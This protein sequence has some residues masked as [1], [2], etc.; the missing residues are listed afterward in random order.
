[1]KSLAEIVKWTLPEYRERHV[2]LVRLRLAI[3]LGFWAI[4]LSF[5]WD[6]LEQVWPTT[7]TVL[8][9]FF[10]TGLSYY[11]VMRDRWLVGSFIIE[12][13]SDLA[14][15]TVVLYLTGGPHS[16]YYTMYVFYVL[17]VGVFYSYSL[18]AIC[19]VVVA[20]CYALF[21]LLCLSG[22]IPPLILDYGDNAPLPGY[23][24]L[25]NYIFTAAFL[26]F[27]IYAVKIASYFSQRREK[28]LELR[29]KEFE[30]LYRMSSTIRSTL[31]LADVRDRVLASVQHGLG[32][33]HVSMLT[34]EEKN[35]TPQ[36]CLVMRR[37]DPL[38]LQL[39]E[40]F[41]VTEPHAS[42][43]RDNSK[44]LLKSLLQGKIAFRK[45]MAELVEGLGIP[46]NKTQSDYLQ[47][48][49]KVRRIVLV[50]LVAGERVL[51]T[52]VGLSHV[53]FVEERLTTRLEAFSNQAA[54]IFE[55]A[56]LIEELR[57]TNVYL[58]QA[59]KVKSEFLATM[60]HELRT[61][62]TA[63][64]GFSELL[65][66]G[67]MGEMT[68]EQLE[69]IREVLHNGQDLLELI[70]GLLDLAKIEAGKM[71]LDRHFFD[72]AELSKR[73]LRLVNSLVQRKKL[74][75]ELSVAASLPSVEADE[76]KVQQVLLN[77]LSN[78][79]KFTP[80]GGQ[81]GI[82]I[83]AD[84][85]CLRVAVSD[86]GIGIPHDQLEAVFEPFHQVDSSMTRS[87][88]GTGLGLAL[89]RQF[90]ELHGGKIWAEQHLPM[91]T[92]FL[93]ELPLTHS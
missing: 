1:M 15:I 85:K 73:V 78:A 61:P 66:E 14:A 46:L 21:L 71:A 40:Y 59:N 67:V 11:H 60:S 27:T 93:F 7:V 2:F 75:V 32:L 42:F 45:T 69:T 12:L 16:P 77:L 44:P 76:R 83:Q 57:I 62:L 6:V 43:F 51:G 55:A 63:I 54:L 88:G 58:E 34:F 19:S 17:F 89:A 81:I 9:C 26:G 84:A 18:A 30:A 31:A 37:D 91:G 29:N 82:H 92:I 25:A 79:I 24:P 10:L 49:F 8:I 68:A 65:C 36:L 23:T 72:M 41:S 70:N 74:H 90:I 48:A 3:F 56:E 47:D 28:E 5:F 50:P 22:K 80:E 35:G 38:R 4:Y 53:D 87:Y 39:R 13:L 64:I 52:L 86:T 20:F 33:A